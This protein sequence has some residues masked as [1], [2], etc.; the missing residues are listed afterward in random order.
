MVKYSIGVTSDDDNKTLIR[1]RNGGFL[2]TSLKANKEYEIWA[3]TEAK[4]FGRD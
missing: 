3:K 4:S 2:K 1:L